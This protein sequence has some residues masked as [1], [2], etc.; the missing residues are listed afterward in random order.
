MIK[1]IKAYLPKF[2]LDIINLVLHNLRIIYYKGEKFTC[3][4][5][6]YQASS[7]LPYGR[8]NEAIK[9]YKIIPMGYR[10]NAL[11][12]KCYS[13]D[14]ERLIYLFIKTLLNNKLLNYNSKIIHF[15]P[16]RA[17]EKNF[18]RKKFNNYLTADIEGNN[19]DFNLDLQNLNF[20]QSNFDL[21]ICNHVLEHIEEDVKSLE[22]IFKLLKPGGFA[23]LQ[24]PFSNLID[25][26]FSVTNLNN[27]YDRFK[28]YGQ[29][30]HVR[31]YSK[32]GFV[33]KIK[34]TG[35]ELRIY[36]SSEFFDKKN[37]LGLIEND[38]IFFA[39]KIEK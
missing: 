24:V 23:I 13:K 6:D 21:V 32:N 26:D 7:F 8:D 15:A 18:F 17:I 33:N 35:F 28:Y 14:R 22:N 16:E 37:N 31:I 27:K 20:T 1:K 11:C 25:E 5:C 34:N 2:V 30:D 9:K 3:P 12:P 10:K 4:I 29:E 19:V 38:E 36:K 39:K